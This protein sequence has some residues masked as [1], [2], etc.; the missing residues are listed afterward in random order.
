MLPSLRSDFGYFRKEN[1]SECLE[2][3]DLKGQALEF[4]LHGKEEKL[5]TSG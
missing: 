2:Q 5:M 4:C 3:P 1:S